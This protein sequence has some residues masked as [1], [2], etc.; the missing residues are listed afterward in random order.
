MAHV[1]VRLDQGLLGP[2][3]QGGYSQDK[4]CPNYGVTAESHP[5]QLVSTLIPLS[6]CGSRPQGKDC[7]QQFP[8]KGRKEAQV[9]SMEQRGGERD[10]RCDILEVKRSRCWTTRAKSWA[11]QDGT[12][13]GVILNHG[14]SMGLYASIFPSVEMDTIRLQY[15]DA[16]MK[17][18]KHY[19]HHGV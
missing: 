6:K 15:K 18:H 12:G 3:V 10:P 16:F 7:S 2:Q 9:W 14:A 1:E 17:T 13:T 4:S 5:P 19:L 11:L 8:E